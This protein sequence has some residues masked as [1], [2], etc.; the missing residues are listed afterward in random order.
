[1]KQIINR[2]NTIVLCVIVSATCIGMII[3]SAQVKD[4]VTVSVQRCLNVIIPSLFAFMALSQ[5]ILK[6]GISSYIAKPFGLFTKYV[7]NMPCDL[8]FVFLMSSIAGYPVGIKMLS[9]LKNRGDIS[10]KTAQIMSA[11]CYCGGPAFYSGTIGLEVFREAK[12]GM[13]IFLS[14]LG[15]NII[16]EII[17]CRLCKPK[18]KTKT[19]DKFFSADILTDSVLSAGKSMFTICAMIIFCSALISVIDSAG[20]FGFLQ[21]AIGISDNTVV[22]LKSCL[23]ISCI[24][25][26]SG[27]PYNLLPAIAAVCSFGGVCVIIQIIALN[28]SVIKLKYFLLSRPVAALLSYLICRLMK[29]F[30]IPQAA[31]ASTSN[32]VLVNFNNFVP[33]ICLLLMIFLLNFKKSLVFSERL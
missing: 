7:L 28:N 2:I 24:A 8:F 19:S 3:F 10:D 33:S 6:S 11:F 5:I 18:A 14:V 29:T 12:I 25:D 15:S 30:Y 17:L 32:D 9:D 31:E 21:K 16:I 1:M 4:A 22:L 27:T 20:F 13:L 26:L 23:E